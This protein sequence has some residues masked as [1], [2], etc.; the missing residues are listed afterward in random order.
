MTSTWLDCRAIRHTK[1]KTKAE[2][3]ARYDSDN[4]DDSDDSNNSDD[5]YLNA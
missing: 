2:L 3:V 5:Q 4:S 1:L